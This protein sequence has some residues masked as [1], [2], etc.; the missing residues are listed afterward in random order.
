MA[1]STDDAKNVKEMHIDRNREI[2]FTLYNAEPKF[3]LE[4]NMLNDNY[5]KKARRLGQGLS[6]S[7]VKIPKHIDIYSFD[8]KS[9]GFY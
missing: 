5:I 4:K 2:Y 1:L 3:Y 9:I 7:N 6:N 8:D